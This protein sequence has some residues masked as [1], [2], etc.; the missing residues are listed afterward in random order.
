LVSD[1]NTWAYSAHAATAV[2]QDA[3][4]SYHRGALKHLI[5]KHPY[6]HPFPKRLDW[7]KP[8]RYQVETKAPAARVF[9]ELQ[10]IMDLGGR[11]LTVKFPNL[12][13]LDD[14]V[15]TLRDTLMSNLIDKACWLREYCY[16]LP[17]FCR[18]ELPETLAVLL[19]MLSTTVKN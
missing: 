14:S 13:G 8:K 15:N 11:N 17:L 16:A 6:L 4:R 3:M 10:G 12:K 2:L 19:F 7:A 5:T 9:C 18:R 1:A